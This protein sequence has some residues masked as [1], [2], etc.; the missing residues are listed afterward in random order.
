MI[1]LLQVARKQAFHQAEMLRIANPTLKDSANR[2]PNLWNWNIWQEASWSAAG[3]A[4]SLQMGERILPAACAKMWNQRSCSQ[5]SSEE[6]RKLSYFTL[7]I[8]RWTVWNYIRLPG[9]V[10]IILLLVKVWPIISSVILIFL[11]FMFM[12]FS[13]PTIWSSEKPQDILRLQNQWEFAVVGMILA[14]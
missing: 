4:F 12:W 7:C 5:P 14:A 6:C 2:R 13:E 1:S 9:I 10:Y 11:S 8:Y 3:S